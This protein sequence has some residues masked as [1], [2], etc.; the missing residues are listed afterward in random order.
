MW[1]FG[2][3]RRRETASPA[4][5]R[6]RARSAAALVARAPSDQRRPSFSVLKS[7]RPLSSSHH[8]THT[9]I[10]HTH[11]QHTYT[12]F[13]S[14][15]SSTTPPTLTRET[16]NAT[17]VLLFLPCFHE[18]RARAHAATPASPSQSRGRQRAHKQGRAQGDEEK[19]REKRNTQ[20]K[21]RALLCPLCSFV[22]RPR[23]HHTLRARGRGNHVVRVS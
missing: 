22:S 4:F 9:H 5:V 6:W 17:T 3:G 12:A 14:P 15:S 21:N 1:V 19:E 23:V 7:V 20:E 8:H 16:K 13:P 2:V 10:T 11:T 18:P